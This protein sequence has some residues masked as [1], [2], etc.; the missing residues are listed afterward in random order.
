MA[1]GIR[2]ELQG[3]HQATALETPKLIA[4]RANRAHR[5]EGASKRHSIAV[6]QH[7]LTNPHLDRTGGDLFAFIP[8]GINQKPL[9][10]GL[11]GE[12][13]VQAARDQ[14]EGKFPQV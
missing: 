11:E 7:R 6:R 12:Q 8:A 10:S 5:F 14:K 3:A 13:P 9:L 4:L 1:R 2:T